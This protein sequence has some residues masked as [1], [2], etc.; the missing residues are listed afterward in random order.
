M[1]DSILTYKADSLINNRRAEIDL[2]K[3]TGL[4]GGYRVNG[5][6]YYTIKNGDT[7]GGI[8]KKFHCTVKQLKQWN[9][10]KNDNIRAGKKL[11]ICK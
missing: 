9:G 6:T 10:L 5:V 11:K 7:L 3:V 4:N 2:A 1:Q 8:A